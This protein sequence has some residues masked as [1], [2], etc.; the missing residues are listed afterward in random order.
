MYGCMN[1][2]TDFLN[3]ISG[4][5]HATAETYLILKVGSVALSGVQKHFSMI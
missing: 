3:N 5:K 1:V 4:Y 2:G